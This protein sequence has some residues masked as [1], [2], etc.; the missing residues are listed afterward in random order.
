MGGIQL[1]LL[2]LAAAVRVARA[3]WTPEPEGDG[4]S[5][6]T[7][8]QNAMSMQKFLP[9]IMVQVMTSPNHPSIS[10]ASLPFQRFSGEKQG[11]KGISRG[12][13]TKVVT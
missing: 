1:C 5:P 4:F 7:L 3:Q 10:S 6:I 13:V 2:L 11:P 9:Y 8:T 12:N